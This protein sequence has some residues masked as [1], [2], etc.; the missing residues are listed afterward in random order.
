MK[1]CFTTTL[2]AANASFRFAL[3]TA[4]FHFFFLFPAFC[5][6]QAVTSIITDYNTFWKS[7]SA[8]PSAVK[9]DNSHNLLAFTHNGIQYSTGVNDALL[10]SHGESFVQGDFWSLPVSSI[11]GSVNGNTKIG[12]GALYDGVYNGASNPT[13]EY[14]IAPYLTDGI[15]GLNLGTGVANLPSGAMT[16]SIQSISPASIGDG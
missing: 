7:T 3:C 6:A 12:L 14:A 10:T 5:T 16:F 9:P 2:V 1:N 13:P 15:K 4:S 11:S 8:T